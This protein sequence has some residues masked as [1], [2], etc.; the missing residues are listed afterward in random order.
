MIKS[1][2]FLLINVY[3]TFKVS[4]KSRPFFQANFSDESQIFQNIQS[5]KT[6]SAACNL[7]FGY[8]NSDTEEL[9]QQNQYETT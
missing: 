8:T 5:E 4:Q 3:Y 7:A 2:K 6:Q 9:N 1:K